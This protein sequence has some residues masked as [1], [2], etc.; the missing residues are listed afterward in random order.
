MRIYTESDNVS[1]NGYIALDWV[2]DYL[3]EK[4]EDK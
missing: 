1:E 2:I 4:L 3:K